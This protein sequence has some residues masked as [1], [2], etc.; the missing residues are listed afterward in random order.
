[1][2]AAITTPSRELFRMGTKS[3]ASAALARVR[4]T[5]RT[6]RS[7]SPAAV[8]ALSLAF[9]FGGVGIAGAATG[10]AFILGRSN[11][12][13]ST[14]KLSDSR[15][16][17]LSLSAPK[18]KAPIAVNRSIMVKNLNAQYLGGLSA[19][20]LKPTGGDGF[21]SSNISIPS[22]AYAQVATTGPLPAG[23]YFV[24]A[25]AQ[26]HV[27]APNTG[28]LCVLPLNND[29]SHP[30]QE[31]GETGAGSFVQAAETVAVSVP[32]KNTV[33]EWCTVQGTNNASVLQ[34]AGI[35][36]IRVLS[37]SGTTPARAGS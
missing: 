35:T 32:S 17:P 33:Q 19:A 21:N 7:L 5:T 13:S 29:T 36:A 25:T 1:M 12:E 27:E 34:F 24:T 10:A 20:S 14:A 11:T 28:A 26:V 16:T 4:S 2:V 31:G 18:N 22:N 23:T 15:G 8:I 37:T 3:A 9:V 30:L 6:A